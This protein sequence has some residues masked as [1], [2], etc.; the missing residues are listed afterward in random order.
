MH[1]SGWSYRGGIDLNRH[2]ASHS[3]LVSQSAT[4]RDGQNVHHTRFGL[5]SEPL[6]SSTCES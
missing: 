3:S 1:R 6:C 2:A 5:W 4:K